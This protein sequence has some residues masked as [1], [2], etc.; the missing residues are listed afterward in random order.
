MKSALT[1]GSV[2]PGILSRVPSGS[3]RILDIG[4]GTGVLGR[5]LKTRHPERYVAGITPAALEGSRL[6]GPAGSVPDAVSLGLAPGLMGT[7][8]VLVATG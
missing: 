7:Q 6:L 5:A 3:R 8:F 2:N 1:Y 4:C